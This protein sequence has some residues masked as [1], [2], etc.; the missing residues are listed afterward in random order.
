MLPV[1]GTAGD[2]LCAWNPSSVK[3]IDEVVRRLSIS[4]H[5]KDL[6][7][8]NEWMFIGVYGPTSAINREDFWAELKGIHEGW[9][10]PWMVGG[11]S[12]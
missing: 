9:G 6:G 12:M 4:I 3:C 8:R 7:A 5:L 2:V 1:V 11:T 10:G